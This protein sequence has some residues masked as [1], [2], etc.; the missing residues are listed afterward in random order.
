[1]HPQ[2]TLHIRTT[3]PP[4][5]SR[6]PPRAVGQ[7]L[8]LAALPLMAGC[9]GP[10]AAPAALPSP[11]RPPLIVSAG[12]TGLDIGEGGVRLLAEGAATG[13]G[14]AA[15]ERT[16]PPGTRT[17]LHR[18]NRMDEAFYV[19]RGTLTVYLDGRLHTLP[20]GSFVL[21]PRG[22]PHAQGNLTRDTL[23]MVSLFAPAGWEQSAKARAALHREHPAGTEEFARRIGPL[24]AGFDLE[25]LGPSPLPPPP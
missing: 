21:I 6:P 20:A 13:G 12:S 24:L 9:T 18:H 17:G 25:P 5:G 23:T 11:G 8:M 15:L 14:W 10:A 7:W 4:P 22:T 2:R 16:E 3:P 1:M 19:V